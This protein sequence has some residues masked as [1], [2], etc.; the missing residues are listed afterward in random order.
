M[1]SAT[2]AAIHS[3]DCASGCGEFKVC[4]FGG[5]WMLSVWGGM[6]RTRHANRRLSLC[7]GVACGALRHPVRPS[8]VYTPD[9][10]LVS[11]R[12]WHPAPLVLAGPSRST[13]KVVSYK[14]TAVHDNS[15]QFALVHDGPRRVMVVHD[16]SR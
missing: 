8:L 12:L 16:G 4:K 1:G 9:Q 15:R 10:R 13:E 7:Y 2:G 6:D 11:F 5:R 3:A 14:F